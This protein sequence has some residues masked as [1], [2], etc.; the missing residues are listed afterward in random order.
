MRPDTP[1]DVAKTADTDVT[2]L[3]VRISRTRIATAM[4]TAREF[5][6]L[7]RSST[8]A[9]QFL[10]LH[11]CSALGRVTGQAIHIG[12]TEEDFQQVTKIGYF[13]LKIIYYLCRGSTGLRPV[14]APDHEA[15]KPVTTAWLKTGYFGYTNSVLPWLDR[16]PP[17]HRSGP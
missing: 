3:K 10:W 7:D 1:K 14:I 13:G 15:K 4:Q 12:H 2:A 16:A 8:K 6:I 17:G 11:H 5:L 9:G